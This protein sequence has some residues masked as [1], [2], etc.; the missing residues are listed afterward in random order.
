[1]AA[2]RNGAAGGGLR[3]NRFEDRVQGHVCLYAFRSLSQN[4]EICKC[5]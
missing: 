5:D 1:M 2:R 3:L 4:H